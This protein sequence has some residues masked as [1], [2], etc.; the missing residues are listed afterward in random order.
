M[1]LA[2]APFTDLDALRAAFVAQ[3]AALTAERAELSRISGE[4]AAERAEKERV[5]EQNDRLRHL[6]RQLQRMQF[7]KRSETIDPGQFTLALVELEQAV[8]SAEAEQ[9]KREP[10][11][12]R[13]RVKRQSQGRG[14]L[15]AHLPRIEV[16]VDP[17][18]K[19]PGAAR[20]AAARCTLSARKALRP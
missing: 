6:I 17:R 20:A 7:G 14:S 4:L 16:V 9:E 5:S 18:T 10:A 8:A 13:E 19:C 11:G 15:P 2:M 12:K 1:T 3:Q